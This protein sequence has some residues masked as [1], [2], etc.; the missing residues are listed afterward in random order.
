MIL[1]CP[2]WDLQ[3]YDHM[4]ASAIDNVV[5]LLKN[6]KKPHMLDALQSSDHHSTSNEQLQENNQTPHWS[7][8]ST[9]LK[10]KLQNN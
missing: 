2:Q 3:L 6:N 10:Y 7:T 9:L 4:G 8:Y 1:T 5:L